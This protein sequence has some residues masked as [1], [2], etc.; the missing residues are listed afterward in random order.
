MRQ[1][2]ALALSI[3]LCLAG[4]RTSPRRTQEVGK[5]AVDA[6]AG[7]QTG[8]SPAEMGVL[9][10]REDIAKGK[11]R[12]LYYGKPWSVGKPLIDDASGLPVEIVEGCAVTRE[13]VGETDAYNRTMRNSTGD[14]PGRAATETG[15]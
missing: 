7:Q 4:C 6:P 11:R 10:A 9:R 13:F 8:L 3:V 12:I 14:S 15:E 5:N 2:F 1:V